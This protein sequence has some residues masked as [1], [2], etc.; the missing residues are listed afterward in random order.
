[1]IETSGTP[2]RNFLWPIFGIEHKK[3]IP[4]TC[5]IALILF[6]YTVLRNLKDVFIITETGGSGAIAFLKVW[7]VIPAALIF[8]MVYSKLS[9]LLT[10]QNLF[11]STVATFLVFFAVFGLVLYPYSE[12]LQPTAQI[13]WL[14][15]HLPESFKYFI[16]LYQHWVY[17]LFYIMAE[18][19][20]SA[21]AALLFWQFANSIVRVFEAKRFYA[22]FYLLANLATAGAGFIT[23]EFSKMGIASGDFALSVNYLLSIVMIAG[24]LI[25]ML[26]WYVDK[27]VIPDPDLVDASI[28]PVKKKKLKLSLWESIKYIFQSKYLALIAILVISY[29]ISINLV[30]VAWKH[31]AHIVYPTKGEYGDFMGT[32]TMVIGLSTFAIIIIGGWLIRKMGWLFAALATPVILGVTGVI[33]FAMVIFE[34]Q[35]SPLTIMLS[36]TPALFAVVIGGIQNVVSKST[37]YALFDP[38]KEMSYIPLDEESKVKGK[39][40]VDVVGGRLGKAGGAVIQS[41]MLMFI[42]MTEIMP[43]SAFIIV[44]IIII[45]IVAVVWL[46]KLFVEVGGQEV[47][48]NKVGKGKE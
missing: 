14:Q 26:Y 39:A 23:K 32:V 21:I 1:M 18:L 13:I 12:A 40:A 28:A 8:F 46:H 25:I 48:D 33:F 35:M 6:D 29:G 24:V 3:F 4:L 27:K 41:V 34:K 30:E 19:W 43:Y 15:A 22:H 47:W 7:G 31:Q 38:T 42:S 16:L 2:L 10:R 9:N 44:A 36:M 11:Y 17:S 5:M 45:W 20:G 37:K